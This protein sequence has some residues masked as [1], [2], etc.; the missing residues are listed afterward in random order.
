M[1][2]DKNQSKRL[3]LSK[4]DDKATLVSCKLNSKIFENI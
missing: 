2:S 1:N 3:S 4:R